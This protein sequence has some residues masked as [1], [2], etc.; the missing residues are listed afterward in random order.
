[1]GTSTWQ[2]FT[3]S[4]M[5]MVICS[6]YFFVEMLPFL[7]AFLPASVGCYERSSFRLERSPIRLQDV[8]HYCY[9]RCSGYSNLLLIF[10]KVKIEFTQF[11]LGVSRFVF[12]YVCMHGLLK[13]I[14]DHISYLHILL[15]E[16]WA[17]YNN[18][19]VLIHFCNVQ[20]VPLSLGMMIQPTSLSC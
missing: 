7:I 12:F 6:T 13:F 10:F 20:M 8:A 14:I 3:I 11:S 15:S 16:E 18:R 4:P 2:I 1:M 9:W 5:R 17:L 19:A